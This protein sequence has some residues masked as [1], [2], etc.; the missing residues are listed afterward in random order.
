MRKALSGLAATV[1]LLVGVLACSPAGFAGNGPVVPTEHR[2]VGQAT[3]PNTPAARPAA[4]PTPDHVVVVMLEN[5]SFHEVTDG[6]SAP[7]ITSLANSGANF[8]QSFAVTHPS[9]PNYLALFSGS[10]QGVIDDSCPH[11]FP[12]ANLASELAGAG[13]SFA[14][15]SESMPA[16]GFTGCTSGEYARKH[17]PWVDFTNVPASSNLV[18]ERHFPT[19]FT[20]LPRVSFVIPNLCDDA[21]DCGVATADKWLRNNLDA[22]KQWA[23]THNSVLVVT[24]DEDDSSQSNQ[25]PTVFTGQHVKPGNYSERID[26]YG[27]L[28]TLEDAFGLPCTANAC[29]ATPIT[30]AWQ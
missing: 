29:S 22:Y 13:L 6:S 7:Y 10:P 26:H 28:R 3:Q 8:S 15:Y 18:Y 30:D 21:H 16:D 17:N 27:V 2:T 19:D 12:G 11:T 9:E 4:I 14:G 5:K 20:Q 1:A 24:F 23:V 25:I